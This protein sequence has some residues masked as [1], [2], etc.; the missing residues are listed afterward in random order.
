M[1]IAVPGFE[2]TANQQS[3]LNILTDVARAINPSVKYIAF[4]SV[5][6]IT[7]SQYYRNRNESIIFGEFNLLTGANI[8]SLGWIYTG[9]G[10]L[11]DS[12]NGPI[13]C[14]NVP[15]LLPTA[16][17]TVTPS[18]TLIATLVPFTFNCSLAELTTFSS[19]FKISPLD[20]LYFQRT[21]SDLTNPA[22]R[23]LT[24][25]DR[26][27][28]SQMLQ[29]VTQNRDASIL[30]THLTAFFSV[31][32]VTPGGSTSLTHAHLSNIFIALVNT[33]YALAKADPRQRNVKSLSNIIFKDMQIYLSQQVGSGA[34]THRN[35]FGPI[36]L[37]RQAVTH[38]PGTIIHE[39][40]HLFD[41]AL[42]NPN[43]PSIYYKIERGG[44]APFSQF[45]NGVWTRG[46]GFQFYKGEGDEA[47]K[48]F[49]SLKNFYVK[50]IGDFGNNVEKI[51]EEAADMFLNWVYHQIS[52]SAFP[53]NDSDPL[54]SRPA[55]KRKAFMDANIA[56]WILTLA[57]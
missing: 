7:V 11:V 3:T 40:G 18:P 41:F 4:G 9:Y 15:L 34:I 48:K 20:C 45:D 33:N 38:D 16:T 17:P 49:Q 28:I 21:L 46:K 26:A 55:Q 22:F 32:F 24:E 1:S 43:D 54:N 2:A 39:M 23:Y 30:Q 14:D 12:A 35:R 13:N 57:P 25:Q 6:S 47:G 27:A 44:L 29:D 42:G 37:Y 36:E 19:G 51:S 5:S 52:G 53:T 8:P 31:Q 50:N 10:M 56:L